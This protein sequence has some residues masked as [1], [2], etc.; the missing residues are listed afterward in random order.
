MP[1][2]LEEQLADAVC[3]L[4]VEGVSKELAQ[5]IVFTSMRLGEGSQ[6]QRWVKAEEIIEIAFE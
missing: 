1:R 3:R 6:S 5:K 2:S 4:S